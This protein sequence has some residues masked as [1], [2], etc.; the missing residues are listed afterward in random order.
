MRDGPG[1][2]VLKAL[3]RWVWQAETGLR[4]GLGRLRSRP[5]FE[6]AGAC[7]GCGACCE[8]PSIQV[9]RVTWYFPRTRRAFLAWQRLVN[10]FEL[11][12]AD[13]DSRTFSFV[14][15]HFDAATR[16]CDSYGSRPG[17]CRD[18]PRVQLGVAWPELFDACGFRPRVID[19]SGL[20]A[21]IEAT[22]L[23]AEAK[24]ALRVRLYLE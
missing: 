18:Y 19:R 13:R 9:G 11:V 17:M 1:R 5:R 3:V 16:R 12:E 21:E 10:G 4:R 14:C 8:R 24:R 23:S 15:T 6:L 20:L 7:G 22:G 2:M